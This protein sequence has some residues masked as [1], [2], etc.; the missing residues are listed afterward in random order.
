MNLDQIEAR[1]A[2][3]ETRAANDEN[4]S[5]DE[6][7]EY[8]DLQ[9]K[10]LEFQRSDDL[11]K[12]IQFAK[13]PA[14]KVAINGAMSEDAQAEAFSAFL[15]SGDGRE[16]AQFALSKG[17]DAAGGYLAP[18]GF[19][20]KIVEEI[21]SYG[22]FAA[23]AETIT[24]TDGNKIEWP[25]LSDSGLATIT[26]E[27]AEM[28]VG[29]DLVFGTASLDVYKYTTVGANNDPLRV[30]WELLEDARFDI[31]ALI[32]RAFARRI[33]VLQANHWINGDGSDEPLGLLTG[34]TPSVTLAS[35]ATGPTYPELVEFVHSIDPF[36]RSNAKWLMN[37]A[38]LAVLRS[39]VDGNERPLY[40]DAIS[41]LS[42]AMP[43]GSLLGFPVV[44]DQ[45]MPSIGDATTPI[46]FGDFR[47]AY[48]IRRVH[49]FELK[50]LT[51]RYADFG[52]VAY[53]GWERAGGTV[54]DPNAYV[55]M[56]AENTA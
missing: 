25:T 39:M 23:E 16:Y 15:R 51:E 26:P 48:V 14:N 53:L 19:R 37:D 38:T 20:D 43:G 1:L 3:F 54:Q 47:Q 5:N 32:R 21:V 35:N 22:G 27:N 42:G 18:D 34:V 4:F 55:V 44:I 28:T 11:K 17:T 45:A 41:G 24:T 6:V 46:A 12:R 29:A 52:Q 33:A 13:T 7:T 31:E 9:A 40:Q 36:Y 10:K 56:A 8:E 30:S 2:E 50:V 49:G